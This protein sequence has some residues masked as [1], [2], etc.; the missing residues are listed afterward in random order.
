M[1]KSE[2]ARL[3][4]DQSR[5]GQVITHTTRDPRPE[6]TNGISYFFE[7]QESFSRLEKEGLMIET[8]VVNGEKYGTSISGIESLSDRS[9]FPVLVVDVHG[10]AEIKSKIPE[11]VVIFLMPPSWEDLLK[12]VVSRDGEITNTHKK[13]HQLARKEVRLAGDVA[14]F[15]I[16]NEEG[17]VGKTVHNI[18]YIWWACTFRKPFGAEKAISLLEAWEPADVIANRLSGEKVDD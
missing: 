13:R 8:A 4:T 15:I 1:G 12:R 18:E 9:M 14:D 11:A 10:A 6:E 2:V 3:L 17:R 5:F 7:T 16:V